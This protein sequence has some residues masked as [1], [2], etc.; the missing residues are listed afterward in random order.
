LRANFYTVILSIG[1]GRELL[2]RVM[3]WDCPGILDEFRAFCRSTRPTI[4]RGRAASQ[5]D[6]T[7]SIS[8]VRTIIPSFSH[9]AERPRS[10]APISRCIPA[11]RHHTRSSNH[12]PRPLPAHAHQF[13]DSSV[14]PDRWSDGGGAR[15]YLPR[16]I[17]CQT[18]NRSE[19]ASD[20]NGCPSLLSAHFTP[21][22]E[23][24]YLARNFDFRP[25]QSGRRPM[26]D[27]R[28]TTATLWASASIPR[29]RH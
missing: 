26:A 29:F 19:C 24:G 20:S 25:S 9:S 14:T 10:A 5:T 11:S 16:G 28:T 13:S 18:E 15:Y 4:L 1:I 23:V 21:F 8:R 6:R 17:R 22:V 7:G 12:A 3:A 2:G 27:S